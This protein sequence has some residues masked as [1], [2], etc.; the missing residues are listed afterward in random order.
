MKKLSLF[1]LVLVLFL[2]SCASIQRDLYIASPQ[3]ELGKELLFLES[4]LISLDALDIEAAHAGDTGYRLSDEAYTSLLQKIEAFL[5]QE[6]D[7]NSKAR[8]YALKGRLHLLYAQGQTA[9]SQKK[10]AQKALQ[11]AEKQNPYDLQVY[12]LKKRLGE[13]ES[14]SKELLDRDSSN[15]LRIE[16]A[17]SFFQNSLYAEAVSSFDSAFRL[18]EPMYQSVYGN[19]RNRA[20]AL[21]EVKESTSK[22]LDSYLKKNS[23][24]MKEL[25]Q[26][27][28]D[29]SS[30]FE[31]ITGGKKYKP[32]DLYL[33]L[34]NLDLF[35]PLSEVGIREQEK[36]KANDEATRRY[37][38]RLLWRLYLIN[39]SKQDQKNIYSQFY[40][41]KTDAKSP[42]LD[43]F[44]DDADFDAILA[45]VEREWMDL[46]DGKHFYPEKGVEFLEL[47]EWIK[48]F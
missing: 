25:V 30:A 1:Y 15:V 19:I 12:V 10:L 2:F 17:L 31:S 33:H 4:E 23:L 34:Q 36:I 29:N 9:K 46:P 24:T 14:F 5:V 48:N 40:R 3:T 38:A 41:K 28:D 11:D 45:C 27:I 22:D 44:L 21:R 7:Q 6:P 8:L 42:I 18:A 20:W 43:V 35:S 39:T 26:V 13:I 16:Q 37:S 32:S 47:L